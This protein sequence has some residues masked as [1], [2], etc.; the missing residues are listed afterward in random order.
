MMGFSVGNF[1]GQVA[2]KCVSL[3]PKF[4][5]A[6]FMYPPKKRFLAIL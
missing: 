5:R 6:I 1:G 4:S 2:A 3:D